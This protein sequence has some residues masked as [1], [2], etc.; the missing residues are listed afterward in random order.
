MCFRNQLSAVNC[1]NKEHF[2]S[3]GGKLLGLAA[4][5]GSG[6]RRCEQAQ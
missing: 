1:Q 4:T 3:A 2:G 6:G 5:G